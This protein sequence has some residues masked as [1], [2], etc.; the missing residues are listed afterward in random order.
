MNKVIFVVAG[1]TAV[2]K[3][4]ISLQIARHLKTAVLSFD[5]RQ[6]YKEMNIGTAKPDP[7]ELREISHYFVNSHS[8]HETVSAGDFGRLSRRYMQEVFQDH[9][10]LVMTGGTGLYLR[11]ALEGMTRMPD[12]DTGVRESLNRI[13]EE[14]GLLPLQEKLALLDPV[15]YSRIDRQNPQRIIRALEVCISTGTPYSY[16]ADRENDLPELPYRV[17][18]VGLQMDRDRLYQR[19]NVRVDQMVAAGLVEEVKS[20]SPY[21][22]HYALKTVGYKEIFRYLDGDLTRDQAVDLVKR[23]TRRY[24]KRQLT[25]FGKDEEMEWVKNDDGAWEKILRRL[26]RT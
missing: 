12:T 20:L 23:N 4:A 6:C 13:R 22:D 10:T 3:T 14:E 26:D 5:S 8:I 16:F 2:G 21:R 25:W 7:E 17:I 19:I 18:K 15:C 24:A 11:A 9:D 1:P